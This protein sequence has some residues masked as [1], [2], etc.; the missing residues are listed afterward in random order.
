MMLS[1]AVLEKGRAK[2]RHYVSCYVLM[3]SLGQAEVTSD[4]S[5]AR[6]GLTAFDDLTS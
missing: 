5:S 4:A 3:R 1:Q 6:I 2:Q